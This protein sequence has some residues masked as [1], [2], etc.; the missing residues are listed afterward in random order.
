VTAVWGT[1]PGPSISFDE[2]EIICVL[3]NYSSGSILP[4]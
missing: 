3:D 4:A 1:V 2:T